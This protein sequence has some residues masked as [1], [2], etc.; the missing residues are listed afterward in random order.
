MKNDIKQCLC[1]QVRLK[2]S[3][4]MR[5]RVFTRHTNRIKLATFV[6]CALVVLHDLS[7]PML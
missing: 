4:S 7:V 3:D 5:L 2:F 6:V 1:K